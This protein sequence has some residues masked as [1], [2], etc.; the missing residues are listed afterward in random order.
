MTSK[1]F[2]GSRNNPNGPHYHPARF[3]LIG[4]SP[5]PEFIQDEES[6]SICPLL[7]PNS[8]SPTEMD[9]LSVTLEQ[10]M[11][12]AGKSPSPDFTQDEEA[13]LL[14][15]SPVNAPYAIDPLR[16]EYFMIL[17]D[18]CKYPQQQ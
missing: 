2:Q 9:P 12:L 5:S 11:L 3:D 7:T 14:A 6:A 15:P 1:D 13:A 16:S 17:Q 4:K 10:K 8:A 18:S